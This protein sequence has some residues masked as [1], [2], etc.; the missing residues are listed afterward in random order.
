MKEV[1]VNFLQED[2]SARV[3]SSKKVKLYLISDP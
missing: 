3:N 1:Q 2:S